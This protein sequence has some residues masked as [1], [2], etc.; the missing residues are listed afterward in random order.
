MK[1]DLS[2]LGEPEI[3]FG[4]DL[5]ENLDSEKARALL[6][7]IT[8]EADRPHRRAELA[9]MFWPNKPEGYGR[10]NL[11]QALAVLRKALGDR[12]S[13][14]PLLITSNR[15]VHLNAGSSHWVDIAEFKNTIETVE[16]HAHQSIDSCD[17]CAKQ[18]MKVSDL[19]RGNF[20][21]GFFLSDCQEFE[22]W[23][24]V[25]RE[26]YQRMMSNA[27]RNLIS[28]HE[29]RKEYKQAC[30]YGERL[31]ALE[32]WSE[33]SHRTMMRLLAMNG[34]RS[35]SLRQYQ[36]CVEMLDNE[37]GVTPT[38]ET[39][40]LFKNIKEWGFE[41]FHSTDVIEKADDIS[42]KPEKK[43][44]RSSKQWLMGFVIV[45]FFVLAVF[46]F[47]FL[48]TNTD[49]ILTKN[50][51]NVSST[52]PLDSIQDD[53]SANFLPQT[54]GNPEEELN[55]LQAIY[56]ATNGNNWNRSDGWLSDDPPCEWYG[57]TCVDG[58]IVEIN[59]SK[60]NLDGS[61]PPEIGNLITLRSLL[62]DGNM[63]LRG[64]IPSE[65]GNLTD[66]EYLILSTHDGGGSEISGTLP[67]ELGQLTNLI[68]LQ[69]DFCLIRGPIPPELGN[70]SKLR[71]LSLQTNQLSGQIPPEIYTL[72]Q[73]DVLA[74]NGNITLAGSLSP[75]I[76]QLKNLSILDLGY[77]NFTGTLPEEL[78]ELTRLRWLSIS[79]NSFEGAL[80][81]SLKNLNI[82]D[83]HFEHTELCE[84]NDPAFQE[85]L[86]TIYELG[87][88]D[89][90]CS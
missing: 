90:L 76:R 3:R 70:M 9:E 80:P 50:F 24:I 73:L 12:D 31:I 88:T 85:W 52:N 22:E 14:E 30:I 10:N 66:L 54:S 63:R 75:E 89:V 32:P 72:E 36:D 35:A 49:W 51:E 61:I 13:E 20:L 4:G 23:V 81:V 19:Y 71:T 34:K 58:V 5:L 57:I 33:S 64:D 82:S 46:S 28:Y 41:N 45:A 38:S 79:E 83:F 68:T 77:N 7:Y 18:L 67:A 40:E 47:V 11:K 87:R 27:L 2:L 65:I 21:A 15:D 86:D 16:N 84:P 29:R 25:N 78:G 60:N 44:P 17:S 48:T 74:L 39:T 59:L 56:I 55:I 6:F 62:L 26:T 37:L 1:L 43:S 42:P 53:E 8:V 69:I